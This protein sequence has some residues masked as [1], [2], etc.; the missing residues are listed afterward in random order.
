[1][2]SAIKHTG[3][4]TQALQLA[5][6]GLYTTDPNP[7]VGCLLV[8]DDSI[9]G[10]GWHERAGSAHAEV[11][12]LAEAGDA[13]KASTAYVTLEPCSHQG[14]TPPCADA[15]IGAGV[16]QVVVA[17]QDP[18]PLVAGQGIERLRTAGISVEI[19]VL[20]QQAIALNPGYISRMQRG[21]PWIRCKLAMSLDGRTAMASGE[22]QWIS[23]EAS[24]QD[25]QRLRARSSAVMTGVGTILADNPS[26]NL[27]LSPAVLGIAGDIRQPL[28]VVLDRELQMPANARTLV[29][30]G[31]VVILT[32]KSEGQGQWA[33]LE[34]AGAT[35]ITVKETNEHLDLKAVLGALAT[36]EM[37]EVLLETGARLSG[38]ML[39]AGLIDELVI[40][41][42]PHIMG[43]S[44]LGLFHLSGLESMSDRI[45]LQFT[46]VRQIGDDLKITV[47][48]VV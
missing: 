4:M 5:R 40:Y 44:G 41:A 34:K 42:A 43:D 31:Q 33:S 6:R 13:A 30:P 32:A 25:V 15:L 8:K 47:R 12:A 10:H 48:P 29:L 2:S 18:N 26:M 19:G 35:L 21:R 45:P 38:A 20:E 22:S 23:S 28:R 46:D 36:L 17:M 27:R 37:N 39:D 14:R 1:M 24:R 16:A 7:R 3:Y 9:V 11:H